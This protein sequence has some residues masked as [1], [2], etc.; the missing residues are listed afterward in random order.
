ML[1]QPSGAPPTSCSPFF[2]VASTSQTMGVAKKMANSTKMT[3]RRPLPAMVA[4]SRRS[5]RLVM[6]TR[7]ARRTAPTRRAASAIAV[8][9][10]ALTSSAASVRSGARSDNRYAS[11]RD[12]SATPLPT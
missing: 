4:E 5:C 6:V 2:V 12:P 3:V 1:P 10:I 7:Q 11:D 9:R 8:S